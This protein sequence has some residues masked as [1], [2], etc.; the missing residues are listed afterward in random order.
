[1]NQK[2]ILQPPVAAATKKRAGDAVASRKRAAA[3][4][5]PITV[6]VA[7]VDGYRVYGSVMRPAHFTDKQ[8]AD[9]LAA[10]VD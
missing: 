1:M 5:R 8:I 3:A 4:T 7:E 2:K 9:A 10:V 6:T